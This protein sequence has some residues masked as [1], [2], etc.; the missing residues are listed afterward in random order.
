[1][2]YEQFIVHVTFG[3]GVPAILLSRVTSGDQGD[4]GT[5]KGGDG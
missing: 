1:M 2:R 3:G 5:R 4:E